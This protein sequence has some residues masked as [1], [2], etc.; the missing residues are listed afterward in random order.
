MTSNDETRNQL[1]ENVRVVSLRDLVDGHLDPD[2]VRRHPGRNL[3]A[4]EQSIRRF[5]AGR[6]VVVDGDGKV[7]AGEGALRAAVEAGVEEVV[8]VESDGRRMVAVVRP[9]LRGN[10]ARA[11]ALTDNRTTD[12]SA[13]DWNA[14]AE[15]VVA[16][17][18]SGVDLAPLGWEEYELEPL[19]SSVEGFVPGAAD[20]G[21]FA[22]G[23]EEGGGNEEDG[24]ELPDV[25]LGGL[26]PAEREELQQLV[27]EAAGA[28]ELGELGAV[29]LRALRG[30]LE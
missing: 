11:Y 1:L 28:W 4:I 26:D 23:D 27:R 12:L 29:L 17:E 3:E 5:G 21:A 19:R 30:A 25:V 22:A 6:S 2:N 14:V 15:Q 9:D 20:P 8:L 16:L 24:L 18:D 7:V 13:F 10:E